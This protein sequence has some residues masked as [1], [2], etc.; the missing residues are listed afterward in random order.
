MQPFY[1][2]VTAEPGAQGE[3]WTVAQVSKHKFIFGT[4][5]GE[6]DAG[7]PLEDEPLVYHHILTALPV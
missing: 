7:D 2:E 6:E 3:E 1:F 5:G 4:D